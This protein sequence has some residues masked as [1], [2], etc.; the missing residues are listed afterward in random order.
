MVLATHKRKL[1]QIF[2]KIDKYNSP[3]IS[4][5]EYINLYLVRTLPEISIHIEDEEWNM[6]ARMLVK[7]LRAVALRAANPG[8]IPS[9]A[10]QLIPEHCQQWPVKT[11]SGVGHQCVPK[12]PSIQSPP[13]KKY[14]LGHS[15]PTDLWAG[16]EKL[17]EIPKVILPNKIIFFLLYEALPSKPPYSSL[18]H[19]KFQLIQHI[20]SHRRQTG[21]KLNNSRGRD[22]S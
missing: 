3:F 21:T 2:K 16:K 1:A 22:G 9:T 6:G 12:H 4:S 14:C 10:P 5:L 15:S 20:I 8:S 13:P 11:E 19:I 7:W 18:S 17:S